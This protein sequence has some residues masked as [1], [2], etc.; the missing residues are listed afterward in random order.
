MGLFW[1]WWQRKMQ[2]HMKERLV[3]LYNINYIRAHFTI[4]VLLGF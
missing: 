2:S 3:G 4:R 1:E